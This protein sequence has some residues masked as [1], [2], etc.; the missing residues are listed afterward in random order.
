MRRRTQEKPRVGM[1]YECHKYVENRID[2][3]NDDAQPT[4]LDNDEAS[5]SQ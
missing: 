5:F 4:S 1:S 2:L 3:L